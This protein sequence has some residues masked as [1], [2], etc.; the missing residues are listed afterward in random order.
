MHEHA[1]AGLPELASDEPADPVCRTGDECRPSDQLFHP[2]LGTESLATLRWRR[3]SRALVSV[4][5]PANREINREFASIGSSEARKCLHMTKL[6]QC[7][8][9][10]F[11]THRCARPGGSKTSTSSVPLLSGAI[12][13][14]VSGIVFY[15]YGKTSS[16]LTRISHTGF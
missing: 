3:Q 13:E 14:V 15:L 2:G 4:K 8:A 7:I 6:Y 1:R 16:Q 12:V 9:S 10:Q 5:F 11:P